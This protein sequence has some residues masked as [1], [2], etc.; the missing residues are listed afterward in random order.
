MIPLALSPM[1]PLAVLWIGSW[2]LSTRM[3]WV[4]PFFVGQPSGVVTRYEDYAERAVA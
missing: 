3:N 2:E 1:I 4:D